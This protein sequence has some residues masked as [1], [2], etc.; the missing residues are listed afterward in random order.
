MAHQAQTEERHGVAIYLDTETTGFSPSQGAGIVEVAIVD[1]RGA[2]LIDTLV[3][4]GHPIPW[5][6]AKVHGISDAMVR[7]KPTLAQLM[8]E[9]RR[10]VTGQQ[11]VIYNATFDAPFFPGALRESQRIDC[12]MRRFAEA[13]GG[14]AW[15]KLDVAASHVRHTW[16]GNAHRALADALACRS[17]WQWIVRSGR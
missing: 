13:T 12:A 15:K 14:G 7:G 17:V 11:L 4:P 3:D 1:E 9:I 5:A 10:I 8:P 2:T 16:S 6:A